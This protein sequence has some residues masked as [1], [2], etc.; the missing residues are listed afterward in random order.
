MCTGPGHQESGMISTHAHIRGCFPWKQCRWACLLL[1]VFLSGGF[2]VFGISLHSSAGGPGLQDSLK[3]EEAQ[4][5]LLSDY[6][7]SVSMWNAFPKLP[8][9]WDAYDSSFINEETEGQRG[10]VQGEAAPEWALSP[11]CLS[12][13]SSSQACGLFHSTTNHSYFLP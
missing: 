1:A 10:L 5:H 7:V 12:P 6:F 4:V 8:L 3:G 9:L 13:E 11:V 2:L